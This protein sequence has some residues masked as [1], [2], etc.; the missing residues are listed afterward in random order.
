ML[1]GGIALIF[2]VEAQKLTLEEINE[3][4]P[5]DG[6]LEYRKGLH[7]PPGVPLSPLGDDIFL[8][9][10]VVAIFSPLTHDRI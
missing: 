5:P 6:F 3:N 2:I 4:N 1:H 10:D 7:P 8:L 9:P